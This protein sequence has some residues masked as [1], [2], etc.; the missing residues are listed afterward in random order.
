MGSR[1][2]CRDNQHRD[3]QHRD[4]K[5]SGDGSA[6][7]PAALARA[8]RPVGC[9]PGGAAGIEAIFTEA[10]MTQKLREKVAA[11]EAELTASMAAEFENRGDL[12][13][14]RPGKPMIDESG[15]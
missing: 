14:T 10:A 7:A 6:V 5:P 2:G 13:S 12:R 9:A 11:S 4:G 8:A 15:T 3:N 1:G